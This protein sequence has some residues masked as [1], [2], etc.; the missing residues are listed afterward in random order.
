MKVASVLYQYTLYMDEHQ[1][2]VFQK[3]IFP[4]LYGMPANE[5]ADGNILPE[6]TEILDSS[7]GLIASIN[8][9]AKNKGKFK[10]GSNI[11]PVYANKLAKN[12][13]QPKEQANTKS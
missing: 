2:R 9:W 6:D 10:K 7:E 3:I 13:K 4:K 1:S 11:N 8:D 5:A 12:Q